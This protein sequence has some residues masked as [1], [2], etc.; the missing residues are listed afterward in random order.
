MPWL[1][2]VNSHAVALTTHILWSGLKIFQNMV[3]VMR[4][5]LLPLWISVCDVNIISYG[6]EQKLQNATAPSNRLGIISNLSWM[7]SMLVAKVLFWNF[8]ILSLWFVTIFFVFVNM[9]PYGRKSVKPL[10]LPQIASEFFQTSPEFSC[11]WSSQK[12]GFRFL[13]F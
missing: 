1:Y 11:Q 4:K 9:G 12:Y 7:F 6:R 13:K 5:I 2:R 8:E 10:L 3:R